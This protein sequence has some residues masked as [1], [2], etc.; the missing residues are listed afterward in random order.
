MSSSADLEIP[1]GEDVSN[2]EISIMDKAKRWYGENV[3]SFWACVLVALA[4]IVMI[5]YFT[6][7]YESDP[8]TNAKMQSLDDRQSDPEVRKLV[9]KINRGVSEAQRANQ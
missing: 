8:F 9:E 7:W 5:L 1:I 4:I 2:K 6:F 3:M